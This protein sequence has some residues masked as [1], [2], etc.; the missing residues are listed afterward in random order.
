MYIYHLNQYAQ[1]SQKDEI[2][3]VIQ[4]QRNRQSPVRSTLSSNLRK[5]GLAYVG[6]RSWRLW[7][8]CLRSIVLAASTIAAIPARP[9]IPVTHIICSSFLFQ[10][11]HIPPSLHHTHNGNVKYLLA[12]QSGNKHEHEHTQ[13]NGIACK[14]IFIPKVITNYF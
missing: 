1:E 4:Q 12:S 6:S 10:Y 2:Q 8:N 9:S 7:L 14:Q 5:I 3:S 13:K 11:S